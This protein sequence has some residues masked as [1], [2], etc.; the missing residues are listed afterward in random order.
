MN[1]GIELNILIENKS[2]PFKTSEV[3]NTYFQLSI[4]G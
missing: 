4:E 3:F 1:A 2:K